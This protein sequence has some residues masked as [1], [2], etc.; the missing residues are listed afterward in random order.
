MIRIGD[1][2]CVRVLIGVIILL[3]IIAMPVSGQHWSEKKHTKFRLWEGWSANLNFGQ[4]SFFGDVSLFDDSFS[5]KLSNE[6]DW[7]FGV[8]A[9][10]DINT[11]L[12]VGGQLLM[13]SLKG[14]NKRAYFEAKLYEYNINACLNIVNLLLP[15]NNS[16]FF[17]FGVAGVGHFIFNSTLNFYDSSLGPKIED[18][19]V[20]EFVYMFGSEAYYQII[21]NV[22]V[23]AG[24]VMRQ[25]RNDKLDLSVNNKDMDY[26]T[27]LSAGI[28]YH[29]NNDA[30][31][32]RKFRSRSRFPLLR[33]K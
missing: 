21:P 7:G 23:T 11:V 17:L 5:E 16:R 8:I 12:S 33:R 31:T 28:T 13:G 14:E 2:S 9:R 18:T 3:Q 32:G 6:S 10:K 26:Y 15:N 27:Y 29:F 25:A 30:G 4:T 20:P 24:M 19:G 22:D 1:L